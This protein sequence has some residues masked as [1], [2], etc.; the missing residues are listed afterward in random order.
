[1]AAPRPETPFADA[2][3]AYLDAVP[4]PFSTPGHKRNPRIFP[5]DLLLR[6][7][8]YFGGA[9]TLRAELRVLE[10]AEA[11]AAAAWGADYCRFTHNG[12][13]H[14][15]QALVL[16]TTTPGEPVL[17]ARTCHKSVYCG[18]ILSG[19]RP[20]WIAPE[21]DEDLG[22]AMGTR[23]ESVAA[24]LDAD[25]AIRTVI[26]TEPS[27][28]GVM[29]DVA[30]IADVCHA[31]GVALVIDHAWAAHFGFGRAVPENAL[32]LGADAIAIST[33]K[34]LPS[35]T[36]GALLLA[37]RDGAIDIERLDACF[38]MLLTTSPSG[39]LYGTIDRARAIM[40]ERGPDLLDAAAAVAAQAREGIR[41]IPGVDVIDD[42]VLA[43]PSVAVRDPLKLVIDLDGARVDGIS[44]DRALRGRGVQVEGA[45]R[46]TLVA[47]L[48]LGD[49]AE[50]V[51]SF[52]AVLR[53][54]VEDLRGSA[55]GRAPVATSWRSIPEQAITPR[56]AFSAR[57]ER[58]PA[59]AAAGRISADF[60]VPYP[61]G[62][63]ALAPGEVVA[64][65]L[66]ERLAAEV[67]A[68][69]RM[70]SASDPTLASLLVVAE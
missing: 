60:A 29:S 45:D 14:P 30:G 52:L 69:V 49:D 31:R 32:R 36:P 8:P 65:D 70:A 23:P 18:L 67:A 33:H 48:T 2:V 17:V 63:P 5:D 28:V 12:S 46:R 35:F 4:T 56:A 59:T 64:G 9:D 53:E 50:R 27:Y 42:R 22:L 66:W 55:T 7:A 51:G 21:V 25:S 39:T 20:V 11:L 38:D 54:V 13:T 68:G 3:D 37:R 43:H 58:V 6:D 62:I 26:L 24:A 16:A 1:M 61:P 47:Q 34:T 19:A 10:D 44:V 41:A 15:N 57:R 40:V